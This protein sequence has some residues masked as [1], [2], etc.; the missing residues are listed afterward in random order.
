MV[1]KKIFCV[2]PA[3]NEEKTIGKVVRE[4][5]LL[6]DKVIVVDD[7]SSD[8]TAA[9]A[10]AAGATVLRHI[11]NRGQGAGLAT[12]NEYSLLAGAEIIVHFDADGQFKAGEI[13]SMV[14]PI[15]KGE[16][17]IV[18]GS[19]F[20]GKKSNLPWAKKN[21][22]LPLARLVN[23]IF[24]RV[25]LSD[26]QSGFRALSYRAAQ[27]INITQDGMAH[28]SEIMAQAF[29][30]RLKIKEVPITVFYQD[31]GQRFSGG[32]KILRDLFLGRVLNN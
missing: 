30:L 15:V 26:P 8:R 31:F 6:V 22:I 25:K 23:F 9:R 13:P 10:R 20:L 16:A 11:L 29:R 19:R 14:A 2:I 18:F 4:V 17:E 28:C 27:K 5:K 1:E 24:L 32:L 3:Y 12:G 21:I 7:G